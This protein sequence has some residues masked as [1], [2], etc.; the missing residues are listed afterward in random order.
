[1]G[2]AVADYAHVV[3]TRSVRRRRQKDPP[4]VVAPDLASGQGDLDAAGR[5]EYLSVE[6]WLRRYLDDPLI[7]R[8]PPGA[9]WPTREELAQLS[10]EERALWSTRSHQ[11]EVDSYLRRILDKEDPRVVFRLRASRRG[12][13]SNAARIRNMCLEVL[14][15][16]VR[17]GKTRQQAQE[18]VATAFAVDIRTV[19]RAVELWNEDGLLRPGPKEERIVDAWERRLRAGK[20]L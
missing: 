5:T 1:M 12:A 16:I 2:N 8:K 4:V 18:L 13:A 3:S 14:R 7:L 6:N 19:Q 17:H 20:L 9:S 11:Y 10:A 15:L